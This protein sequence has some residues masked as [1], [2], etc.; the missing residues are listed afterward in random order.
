ME[1]TDSD[2]DQIQF[3]EGAGQQ[4]AEEHSLI[5]QHNPQEGTSRMF[6]YPYDGQEGCNGVF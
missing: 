3:D 2:S 1:R 5:E 6:Q 4:D